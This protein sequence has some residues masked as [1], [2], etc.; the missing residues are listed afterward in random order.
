MTVQPETLLQRRIQ[1]LIKSKGGYV[2]KNWGNMTSEPGIADL[3][4]CYKG[5]YIA[6]EVKDKGNTPSSAQGIHCRAVQKAGGLTIV[7]WS[8]E[9]V[10]KFL[11]LVDTYLAG[12][13]REGFFSK[14]MEYFKLDDGTRW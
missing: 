9:E 2:H 11:E 13:I 4:I 1:K 3:T 8:I 5:L 12:E 7:V 10:E 6:M 14:E